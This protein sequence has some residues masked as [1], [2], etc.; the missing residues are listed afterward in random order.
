MNIW[1]AYLK[2]KS[3]LVIKATVKNQLSE[4][5]FFI[6]QTN[7]VPMEEKKII[8]IDLSDSTDQTNMPESMSDLPWEDLDDVCIDSF[9]AEFE[10]ITIEN[11]IKEIQKEWKE[12]NR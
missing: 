12:A 9:E 5:V 4:D 7:L 2:V 8:K 11:I 3:G 1:E 10:E 6:L